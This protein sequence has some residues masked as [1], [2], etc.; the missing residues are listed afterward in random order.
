MTKRWSRKDPDETVKYGIDWSPALEVG[1]SIASARFV[2]VTGSA[3]LFAPAFSGAATTVFVSGG[4]LLE[5]CEILGEVI[6]AG[7]EILQETALLPIR[8]R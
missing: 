2:V 1:D 6:T 5:N 4:V 7:G 3:T 8:K